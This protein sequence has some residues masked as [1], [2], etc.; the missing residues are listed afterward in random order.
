M[1]LLPS[2]RVSHWKLW[3][4]C[5]QGLPV[6]QDLQLSLCSHVAPDVGSGA[7]ATLTRK[8]RADNHDLCTEPLF[9]RMLLSRLL[10]L[11]AVPYTPVATPSQFDVRLGRHGN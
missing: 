1:L 3:G 2:G 11:I 5:S 8:V 7:A 10:S 6:G 9:C 4:E